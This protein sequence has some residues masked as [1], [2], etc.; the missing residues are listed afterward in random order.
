MLKTMRINILT[1]FSSSDYT[2]V[3]VAVLLRPFGQNGGKDLPCH[4]E[5]S[6]RLG[7]NGGGE[8]VM[9]HG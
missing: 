7:C 8:V 2:G 1:Q 3:P 9:V 4:E 6:S 5:V